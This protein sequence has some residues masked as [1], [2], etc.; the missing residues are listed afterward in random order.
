MNV[1]DSSTIDVS[2]QM[3]NR[4][5]AYPGYKDS[6]VEWLGKI[7][8]RWEICQLKYAL[9]RNDSGVWGEDPD[10][11]GTI[12]LRSTDMTVDGRWDIMEPARRKL[13]VAEYA[14]ARLRIGD[15][16]VTKSSGSALHLGK[17]ALVTSEVEAL[18]S[19]FSN[20]MQRLRPKTGFESGYIYWIINSP[21]GREQL[22]YLGSTTTGLAN[23]NGSVIGSICVPAPGIAEQ[24]AIADFLDHETAKIDSLVAKQERLI[25]LLQEK[26]AALISRAVT[27]GLNPNVPMKDSGI[28]WLGK[29]PAHWAIAPVYARYKVQLGKMLDQKQ[30]TGEH[31]RPYL[32]NVDVQWDQINTADLPEM[33]FLPSSRARFA[34]QSGDLLVCEGGEVGRAAIWRGELE[35]CYYQK[36]LHRLRPRGHSDAPRFLYYVLY[37]AAKQGIFVASGNPN[38]IDHLTAEKLSKHRFAFPPAQEQRTIATYL[39]HEM[40]KLDTLIVKVR[41]M[42]ERLQEYRT[43]LISAAVTGKIDVR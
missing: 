12:V 40:A 26:R 31:L 17:T 14:S 43:A 41:G 24:R 20:F 22:N 35:E 9:S 37:N 25:A 3:D 42:I 6:G 16:V 2:G 11:E 36:A 5:R 30:I 34:L 27:K 15:L 19:C 23:L 10:G 32:R 8:V 39:D 4:W 1:H 28:P 18:D 13:S 29:I 33:D 38:T 7:P 21:I